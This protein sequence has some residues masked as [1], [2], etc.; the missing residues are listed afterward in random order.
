M[1]GSLDNCGFHKGA[2]ICNKKNNSDWMKG[3]FPLK[4][5][6]YIGVCHL[7]LKEELCWLKPMA[8]LEEL[9]CPLSQ[10]CDA[11]LGG[12]SETDIEHKLAIKHCRRQL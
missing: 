2:A 12:T 11:C 5:V 6:A 4:M 7:Q 10:V 3:F 1:D 9:F 8:I